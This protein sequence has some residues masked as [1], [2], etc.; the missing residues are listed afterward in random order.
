MLPKA[1]INSKNYLIVLLYLIIFLTI[2]TPPI[3]N[4]LYKKNLLIGVDI[5]SYLLSGKAIF[6]Q[7]IRHNNFIYSFPLLPVI[8]SILSVSIKNTLLSY[9]LGIYINIL[10]LCFM[11][12]LFGRWLSKLSLNSLSILTGVIL[13]SFFRPNLEELAWGGG[14]QYLSNIFGIIA[15][16][17]LVTLYYNRKEKILFKRKTD[18]I[19]IG[20]PLFLSLISELYSSIYWILTVFFI[21]LSYYLSNNILKTGLIDYLKLFLFSSP[22]LFIA[23]IYYYIFPYLLTE[24]STVR[25]LNI[26]MLYTFI[27]YFFKTLYTL[28][29]S[30]FFH[31]SFLYIM[32][33]TV[34]FFLFFS[35]ISIF[36]LNR[37]RYT[38]SN[39]I[40][41]L[42]S[43]WLSFLIIALITPTYYAD[44]FIYFLFFPLFTN[45][46]FGTEVFISYLKNTRFPQPYNMNK[47]RKLSFIF[48]ILFLFSSSTYLLSSIEMYPDYL[49][50]Y[51]FPNYHITY[52][53]QLP[54]SY[55]DN[56][57][58][59]SIV[60]GA[61]PFVVAYST[62]NYIYPNMQPVWYTRTSQVK[63]AILGRLLLNGDTIANISSAYYLVDD[64]KTMK[65]TLFAWNPP[66]FYKVFIFSSP[67]INQIKNLTH[68]IY[69]PEEINTS[70]YIY[71]KNSS[72]IDLY[73]SNQLYIEKETLFDLNQYKIILTYTVLEKNKTNFKWIYLP[74][75][76]YEGNLDSINITRYNDTDFR[77]TYTIK[78]REPWYPVETPV[79][80]Y[81]HF[82]NIT[83]IQLLFSSYDT[84]GILLNPNKNTPMKFVISIQLPKLTK[85]MSLQILHTEDYLLLNNISY[86]VIFNDI[87]LSQ[88][89]SQYMKNIKLIYKDSHIQIYQ[90]KK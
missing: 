32:L 1:N 5:G 39:D 34:F 14:S 38:Y 4:F 74:P 66:Y 20:I 49:N 19:F 6:L 65:T 69:F 31:L 73:A 12:F 62:G 33:F 87:F 72:I 7:N 42:R 28:T 83:G 10:F 35:L 37:V 81:Y 55:L 9:Q 16:S 24:G 8:F 15:L 84:Y 22:V 13:S 56:D 54:P 51:S 25:C 78:Y 58:I 40:N 43:A 79:D 88:S 75:I 50:Y 2:I 23:L 80:V 57:H 27:N 44:R 46:S 17:S 77:L 59:R 64:S 26:Y 21:L 48:I 61:H 71:T 63:S 86:I 90:L 52:K 3:F 76:K 41:I 30:L 67:Y 85:R 11:I 18:Y 70:S 36:L 82:E 29:F 47:I 53:N 60:Y 68:Q 89:L 45:V